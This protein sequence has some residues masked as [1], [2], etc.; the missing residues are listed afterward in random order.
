[1]QRAYTLFVTSMALE[2]IRYAISLAKQHSPPLWKMQ[3]P[4]QEPLK[5]RP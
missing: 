1:M 2:V 3:G 4:S 5:R